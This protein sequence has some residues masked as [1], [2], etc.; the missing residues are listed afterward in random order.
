MAEFLTTLGTLFTAFIGWIGDVLTLF[1]TNPVLMVM[2]G[3]T[4]FS[5]IVG[6]SRRL[7]H[8]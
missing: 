3:L 2:V 5:F 1:T 7:L 8:G 6:M 4:I